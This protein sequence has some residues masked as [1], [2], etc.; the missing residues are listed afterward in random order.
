MYPKSH[1]RTLHMWHFHPAILTLP[2]NLRCLDFYLGFNQ[3]S[4]KCDEILSKIILGINS[5]N[6]I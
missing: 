4:N 2:L 6:Q 5:I 3:N 1:T